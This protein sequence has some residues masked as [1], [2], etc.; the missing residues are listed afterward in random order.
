MTLTQ[1]SYAVAVDTHRHF[2]RAAEACGVSQPTLSTQ[3]RKL[4]REL[5]VE[6]FDRGRQPVEPTD[7]GRRVLS[8]A[9]A[10]LREAARV[11]EVV[12]EGREEIS[13]ELRIGMLPTLAP[14]VLPRFAADLAREHPEVSLSVEEG[15]TDPLLER[16]ETDHLDAA[17]IA[18]PE[19]SP[20]LQERPLY[21]E[22]FVG[23]V[24]DSHRLHDRG[25]L[26]RDDLSLEDLWILHEG[27]C[28]RDQVLQ[29]CRDLERPGGSTRR[30]QF[31]SGNLET[32]IRLVDEGGGMTL[33]PKLAVDGLTDEQRRR[34]RTFRGAAP[35]RV[36][37]LVH[38]KTYLKR[39]MIEA[40]VEA[41]L[42]SI[43]RSLR[44]G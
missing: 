44:V 14:Y 11:E 4:E 1:L 34:V 22:P 18:T 42:S 12:E 41:L 36:V 30:L 38:G 16:V 7:L 8:Q 33:L 3:L 27:H 19:E 2:S 15:L 20:A 10:V 23:Y 13:G 21:E 6:I 17:L 24:S 9:R 25:R 35:S 32:L 5:G 37:R 28:F 40:F 29:V 26:S 39:G 31:E 43:P